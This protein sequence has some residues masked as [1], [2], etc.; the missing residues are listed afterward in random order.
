MSKN[1]CIFNA[2][3]NFLSFFILVLVISSFIPVPFIAFQSCV[4]KTVNRLST[5]KHCA[6]KTPCFLHLCYFNF[7]FITSFD[8]LKFI[9]FVFVTPFLIIVHPSGIFSPFKYLSYNLLSF[10]R[11][12]HGPYLIN[13]VYIPPVPSAFQSFVAL[14]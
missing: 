10:S 5:E 2:L 4:M 3:V 9:R 11:N 13:S 12:F 1:F 14:K 8:I 7:F 6:R